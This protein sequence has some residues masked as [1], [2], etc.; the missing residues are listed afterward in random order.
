[1]SGDW[2]PGRRRR[3]VTV[4][5]CFATLLAIAACIPSV[6]AGD[7][8][9]GAVQ[10][11]ID[12]R[13]A[14]AWRVLRAVDCAR[15]H[16]RDYAGLAAPSIVGYAGTQSREDFFRMVL[17]GDPPRGMPGYR[18]NAYVA[19]SLDG[20]YRYFL[21]RSNGDIGPEYRPGL[22]SSA[23]VAGDLALAGGSDCPR[24]TAPSAA[25]KKSASP[26]QQV[27]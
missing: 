4:T 12:A 2:V 16:G 11:C 27:R 5:A 6:V 17:D 10:L 8:T 22:P 13:I 3:R 1:V 26:A 9:D 23:D 19:E 15:C 14:N 24:L 18:G 20:I 25:P 7:G 21:A